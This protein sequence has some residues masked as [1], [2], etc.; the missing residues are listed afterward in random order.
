[1]AGQNR[2]FTLI[3][4]M[5]ALSVLSII[6]ITFLQVMTSSYKIWINENSYLAK[7]QRG[8]MAVQT[9]S[10]QLRTA[11]DINISGDKNEIEFRCYYHNQ[12]MKWLKYGLYESD[13]IKALGIK[14]ADCG[15]GTVDYSHYMPLINRVT[16]LKFIKMYSD[17]SIYKVQLTVKD[18]KGNSREYFNCVVPLK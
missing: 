9:I 7:S 13:G 11:Q 12:D 15:Q 4:V 14:K 18:D 17:F 10:N 5:L 3:E 6:S 2:G 16:D 1:M 8:E